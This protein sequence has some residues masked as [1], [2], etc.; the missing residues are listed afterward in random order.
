MQSIIL[1]VSASNILGTVRDFVNVR[2]VDVPMLMR[3]VSANL[4]LRLFASNEGIDPYPL[5]ELSSI[6][7]WQWSMDV[8]YNPDNG[9]LITADN[10]NISVSTIE[11]VINDT[12]RTYTEMVIP[13]PNMNTD[14]LASVIEGNNVLS[15]VIGELVGY[16]SEGKA[17]F[18]L[19]I[20]GFS[21][22]NK[23][24][25]AIPPEEIT[26]DYLT[27]VQTKALLTTGLDI[28]FASIDSPNA[29]DWHTEQQLYDAYIRVRFRD[30]N[31]EWVE[32]D[33]T[34]YGWSEAIKL[35][36]GAKG[37]TGGKGDKGDRGEPF[38]IDIVASLD[39]LSLYSNE[40]AGFSF[41]DEETG[42]V[43]IKKSDAAAD[44]SDPIPFKGEPGE[45][46]PPGAAGKDGAPGKDGKDGEPGQDGAQ[47]PPGPPG[48]PLNLRIGE[49]E[50]LNP[51]E[52][53]TVVPEQDG[54]DIILHIGIPR[55]KDGAESTEVKEDLKA[56]QD[57]VA[58]LEK[59][60]TGFKDIASDILGEE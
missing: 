11:C 1:Y 34:D 14:K 58:A 59:E 4:H 54:D 50:T 32:G 60:L 23:I 29:S 21:I 53:A 13:I 43:Y 45:Q 52:E 46:G 42:Y 33:A 12:P 25:I 41:L 38:K 35:P 3:G 10:D 5:K 49:V 2:D 31:R 30:D 19:L 44:W 17:I 24:S 55:G 16:S 36:K 7:K 51:D 56:V 15:D 18:A 28:L 57:R 37:D 22:Y 47:G 26:P 6:A 27:A 9:Y 48:P 39:K 40:A 20:Q 8:D